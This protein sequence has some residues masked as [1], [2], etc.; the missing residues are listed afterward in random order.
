MQLHRFEI[1]QILSRTEKKEV[2]I[3][4]TEKRNNLNHTSEIFRSYQKAFYNNENHIRGKSRQKKK[5]TRL[6]MT[7]TGEQHKK[8][9]KDGYMDPGWV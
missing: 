1:R 5:S 3:T 6:T 4:E 2:L 7:E 8:K 9:K